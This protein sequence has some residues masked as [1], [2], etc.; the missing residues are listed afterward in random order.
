MSSHYY[1]VKWISF[2]S[3]KT[4]RL[5]IIILVRISQVRIFSVH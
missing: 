1:V 4:A 2:K 5:E 3:V